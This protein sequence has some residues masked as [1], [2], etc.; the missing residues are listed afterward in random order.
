M[1]RQQ[2]PRT[3]EYKLSDT[4]P[5]DAPDSSFVSHYSYLI[6]KNPAWLMGLRRP[7]GIPY[8]T[9]EKVTRC[10]ILEAA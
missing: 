8:Y 7:D 10:D 6:A 1:S 3:G 4:L 2:M 5:V 9:P